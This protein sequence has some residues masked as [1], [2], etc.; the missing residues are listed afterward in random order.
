MRYISLFGAC[1][2]DLTALA[3]MIAM[4]FPR[5]KSDD[6]S[7]VS[8]DCTEEDMMIF[9]SVPSRSLAAVESLCGGAE[10]TQHASGHAA[11]KAR[12]LQHVHHDGG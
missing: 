2:V 3:N 8:S 6:S 9:E 12:D 1:T 4:P 7:R 5:A 10:T 11:G